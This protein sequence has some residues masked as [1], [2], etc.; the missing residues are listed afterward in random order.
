MELWSHYFHFSLD[1]QD[2]KQPKNLKKNNYLK[3]NCLVFKIKENPTSSN[4]PNS[5]FTQL[6]LLYFLKNSQELKDIRF[7]YH[8]R[9]VE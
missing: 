7:T 5:M 3:I 2:R 9:I 6:N 1:R 8:S 4:F